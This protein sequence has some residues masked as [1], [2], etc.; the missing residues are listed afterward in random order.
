MHRLVGGLGEVV[1]ALDVLAR[2]VMWLSPI[3]CALC[4]GEDVVV[5]AGSS[6]KTGIRHRRSLN[7][8]RGRLRRSEAQSGGLVGLYRRERGQ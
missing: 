2:V 8:N 4:G 6:W 5:V 7:R 1:V 3:A